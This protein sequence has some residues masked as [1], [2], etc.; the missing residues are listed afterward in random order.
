M[1]LEYPCRNTVFRPGAATPVATYNALAREAAAELDLPFI[2][3]GALSPGAP[4]HVISCRLSRRPR[5]SFP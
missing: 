5:P 4:P 3:A 1:I 2:G